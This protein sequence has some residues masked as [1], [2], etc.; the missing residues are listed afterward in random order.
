MKNFYPY[1]KFNG[2][3]NRDVKKTITTTVVGGC[4]S[5][6]FWEFSPQTLGKLSQFDGNAYFFRDGLVQLN[7]Q[8]QLNLQDSYVRSETP[9]VRFVS[10]PENH[11]VSLP[12]KNGN[13]FRPSTENREV[14][15]K[16]AITARHLGC[17]IFF[18]GRG[19]HLANIC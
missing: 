17:K 4:N 10:P 15:E 3:F 7:H 2:S 6:I 12:N 13:P 1:L 9:M 11:H 18:G 16:Y 5:N 19:S 8:P 14:W